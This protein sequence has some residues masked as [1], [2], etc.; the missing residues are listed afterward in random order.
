MKLTHDILLEAKAAA[1][2]LLVTGTETKNDALLRMADALIR[3][4]DA[5]LAANAVDMD[6]AK[7]KISEVM[8]DRL[9][10]SASRIEGMAKGIREVAA[11]PDPLR[12]IKRVERS[13]GMVIEKTAVPMG[14]IA[15][16]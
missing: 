4:T 7:G 1:P 8:L 13:N 15:I 16:I 3:N 6:A 11:L 2:A 5:I 12:V 9:M 14:V 10:L